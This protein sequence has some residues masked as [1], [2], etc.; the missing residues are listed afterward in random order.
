MSIRILIEQD[1]NRLL[2]L[3]REWESLVER[4]GGSSAVFL[5]QTWI[6]S[7]WNHFGSVRKTSLRSVFTALED[8]QKSR[9]PFWGFLR[10]FCWLRSWWLYH[11]CD[12][13]PRIY[14]FKDETDR[15]VGF[16]PLALT[17]HRTPAGN[18]AVLHFIGTG[19]ADH[20]DFCIEPDWRSE[21]IGAFVDHGITGTAVLDLAE[22]PEDSPNLECLRTNLQK[23]GVKYLENRTAECPYIK[24]DAM[25]WNDFYSRQRSKSTRQ[26]LERRW[27]QLD[28]TSPVTCRTY[29]DSESIR[30]VFPR[31]VELYRKRWETNYNILIFSGPVESRFYESL[32]IELAAEGRLHLMTLEQADRVLAFTYSATAGR[33][34]TWL[35]TSHDIEYGRY[36][37]G[38]QLLIRLLEDVFTMQ[39]FAEFDMTRGD[40]SYKFKWTDRSRFNTRITAFGNGM[41]RRIIWGLMRTFMTLKHRR[42]RSRIGAGNR[43]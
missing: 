35:I 5:T 14:L 8:L 7:W 18:L 22:I 17:R 15:L 11:G 13:T 29:T 28:K 42:N 9:T 39:R 40:E 20:M 23:S 30:T 3:S 10:S 41:K 2:P 37:I 21:A 43:E 24:L 33:Y 36:F 34:F 32:A 16:A 31:L 25:K 26:D 38:E 12:K 27:R 1:L 4:H 19:L 6:R